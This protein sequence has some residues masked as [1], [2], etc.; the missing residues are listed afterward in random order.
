MKKMFATILVL[1][2]LVTM[3]ATCAIAG[4]KATPAE[5]YDLTLKAYDVVKSLGKEALPAFNDPKGEFVYKD[6]YVAV[7]ICPSTTVAHP[8]AYDKLK[9]VDMAA[10]YP[11]FKL[12][13][14]AADAP[15]GGW[16]EYDWPKPGETTPSRKL[17][18]SIKVQGTPYM[19][20]SGIYSDT[21]S[22]AALNRSL[23]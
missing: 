18:F 9:N 22:V 4:E 14:A 17:S 15:N 2:V 1:S 16:V 7:S 13:C 20:T 11:W 3:G 23:K 21:D 8:F 19:L 6:T 5:V 12:L 10:K